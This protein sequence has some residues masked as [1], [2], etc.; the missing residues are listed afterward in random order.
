MKDKVQQKTAQDFAQAYEELCKEYGMQ[1]VVNPAF[2]ARDDGTWSVV[3]QPS[4]SKLPKDNQL[5]E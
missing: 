3:L 5:Q 2:K 1:L 4:V